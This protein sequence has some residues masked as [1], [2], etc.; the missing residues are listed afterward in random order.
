MTQMAVGQTR[1]GIPLW[2]CRCTNHFG[3][4]FSVFTG[5][6]GILTHSQIGSSWFPFNQKVPGPSILP[7]QNGKSPSCTWRVPTLGWF[8]TPNNDGFP[9]GRPLNQPKKGPG[10]IL[11]LPL[12]K[13]DHTIFLGQQPIFMSSCLRVP[14]PPFSWFPR[15]NPPLGG[16]G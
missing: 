14:V 13:G 12:K 6:C 9:F 15:G 10:A 5:G 1:F 8:W 3:T 11:K 7:S 4:Y 16:G 2:G